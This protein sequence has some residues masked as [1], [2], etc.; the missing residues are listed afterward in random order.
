MYR[1]RRGVRIAFPEGGDE[2]LVGPFAAPVLMRVGIEQAEA[3]PDVAFGGSPQGGRSAISRG[4]N[5]YCY[6]ISVS[7]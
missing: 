4:E 3:D 2:V 5:S 1:L 7:V 6:H